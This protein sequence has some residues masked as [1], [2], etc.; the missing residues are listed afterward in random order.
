MS[1]TG[2]SQCGYWTCIANLRTQAMSIQRLFWHGKHMPMSCSGRRSR[3]CDSTR[4]RT[5]EAGHS[6]YGAK[7]AGNEPNG[8]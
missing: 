2:V 8:G 4:R 3:L 6:G 1:W 7:D 5:G